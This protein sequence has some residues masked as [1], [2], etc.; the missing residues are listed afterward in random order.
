MQAF[1][2]YVR[3]R[4]LYMHM[5]RWSID[6]FVSMYLPI[7]RETL[8]DSLIAIMALIPRVSLLLFFFFFQSL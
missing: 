1:N 5:C 3:E 2:N 8:E 4:A 7:L 6:N